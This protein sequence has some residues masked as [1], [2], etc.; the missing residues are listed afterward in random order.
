[1]LTFS[2]INNRNVQNG[3]EDY[4]TRLGAILRENVDLGISNEIY[5]NLVLPIN[6]GAWLESM[7]KP[8]PVYQ[9]LI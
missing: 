7:I 1:M 3:N 2:L 4:W 9:K 6:N 8:R 5:A